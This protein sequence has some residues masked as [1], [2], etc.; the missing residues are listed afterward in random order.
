[1]AEA[2]RRREAYDAGQMT[3]SPRL[4]FRQRVR[5][6]AGLPYHV[7]Y[8]QHGNQW[9][10]MAVTNTA[11]QPLLLVTALASPWATE[12]M[13]GGFACHNDTGGDR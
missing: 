1:M 10:V 11:R 3:A 6:K 9:V 8:R 4:K 13:H 7:I 5:R 12:V 2:Q